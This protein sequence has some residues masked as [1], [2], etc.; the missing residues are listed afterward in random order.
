MLEASVGETEEGT[1]DGVANVY[2][3]TA[4]KTC[5]SQI[6]DTDAVASISIFGEEF[7]L[8]DFAIS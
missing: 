2:F 8:D 3:G 5:I 6:Y 7:T 1:G 4:S